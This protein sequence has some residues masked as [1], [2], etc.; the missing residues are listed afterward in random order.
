MAPSDVKQHGRQ[1]LRQDQAK[2]D[3]ALRYGFALYQGNW[4]KYIEHTPKQSPTADETKAKFKYQ[5]IQIITSATQV[6]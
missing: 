3:G 4:S 6:A 5:E 2:E 1:T